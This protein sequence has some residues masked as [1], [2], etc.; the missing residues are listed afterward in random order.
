MSN[1]FTKYKPYPILSLFGIIGLLKKIESVLY[2]EEHGIFKE[3]S[4]I[5]YN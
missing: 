3:L 5:V 2:S 1:F 4:K